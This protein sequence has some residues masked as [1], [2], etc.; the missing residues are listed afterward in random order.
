[1]KKLLLVLITSIALISCGRDEKSVR[2]SNGAIIQARNSTDIH[3]GIGSKVC[4]R[5][6]NFSNWE[7]CN[8][9]ELQDTTYVHTY[10]QEGVN[11]TSVVTH[12][13]GLV[14]SHL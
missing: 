5:K 7:I 9:G 8:D 6:S 4:V 11:K 14:S 10:K 12:K 1:M 13:T 2:L 3:Y